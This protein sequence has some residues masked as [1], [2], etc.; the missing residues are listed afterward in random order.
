[1]I[2]LRLQ[3]DF[4]IIY[5][6]RIYILLYTVCLLYLMSCHLIVSTTSM[7]KWSVSASGA[8]VCI[9]DQSGLVKIVTYCFLYLTLS[10]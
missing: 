6:W 8:E 9:F 4:T 7:G 10:I 3:Q 5:T 2:S 1:M